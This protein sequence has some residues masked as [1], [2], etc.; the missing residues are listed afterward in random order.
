MKVI[1]A[2]TSPRRIDLLKTIIENFEVVPSNYDETKTI[3]KN[4][5]KLVKKLSY[6]K[7]GVPKKKRWREKINGDWW[8]YGSLF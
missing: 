7:W 4:P 6:M 1:L 8:R 5:K 3:E 2:S